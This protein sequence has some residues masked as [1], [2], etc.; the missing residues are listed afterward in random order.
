M[1]L[2]AD[3]GSTKTHWAFLSEKGVEAEVFTSGLNPNHVSEETALDEIKKASLKN[4]PVSEIFFYG[5]G[6]GKEENK[7]KVRVWLSNVF[8]INSITVETDMLGA[9]RSLSNGGTSFIAI[10]G[11]GSNA[12]LFDGEKIIHAF[13]SPGFEKGD[14][15]SGGYIGK[16]LLE[17]YASHRM[18]V[19]LTEQFYYQSGKKP[20]QIMDKL[21]ARY[22][23][24]HLPFIRENIHHPWFYSLVKNAFKEFLEKTICSFPGYENYP[25]HFT[26][27]V[28]FYFSEILHEAANEKMVRIEKIKASPM[29]GLAEY[30]LT[31]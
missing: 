28:A 31:N 3:S 30:H 10:L 29:E 24:S 11:T 7:V 18:P 13:P 4:M 1:K 25:V 20:A 21:T 12:C 5:A 6:C 26:G 17:D 15:G 23:A 2:I 16:K 9:A 14:E 19:D 22:A 8:S 27:S